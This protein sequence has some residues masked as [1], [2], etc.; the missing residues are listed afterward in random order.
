MLWDVTLRTQ[1]AS[2]LLLEVVLGL[3]LA[4]STCQIFVSSFFGPRRT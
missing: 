1:E 3:G 2:L 4:L